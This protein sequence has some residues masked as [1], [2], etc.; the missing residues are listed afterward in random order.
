Q[1]GVGG[2]P[3]PPADAAADAPSRSTASPSSSTGTATQRRPAASIVARYSGSDGSSTAT[4]RAP[5]AARTR[6]VRAR[7]WAKPLEI[8]I[9]DGSATPP[10]TP[11]REG[12]R[13]RR[14][15]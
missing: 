4:T 9:L 10:R 12:T 15:S 8:T 2:E 13:A 6:I 11:L 5:L 14:D 3:D 1:G 7:P